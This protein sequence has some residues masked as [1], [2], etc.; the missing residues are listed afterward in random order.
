M[1]KILITGSSGF[2]GK[3]L[4][5]TLILPENNK[6]Y[7]ITTCD[8][9]DCDIPFDTFI[10]HDYWGKYDCIVHMGAVSE[11][12]ATDEYEIYK[13]NIDFTIKLLSKYSNTDCKI[14]YASSASVYGNLNKIET[15]LQENPNF[16]NAISRYAISKLVIDNIVRN[17]YS[18]NPIIGL[19]FF[20]VCSN[21][22]ESHK[23][24][25]SP[26]Y[27]FK[28]ELISNNQ[29]SLFPNSYSII[30]DFIHISDVV[31]I[32][33]FFID[34]EDINKA[35]IVNVGT[36]KS[37]SF[38]SIA[39]ALIMKYGCTKTNGFSS[40]K[41]IDPPSNLTVSYQKFTQADISKLRAM[42]YS[43]DI[44]SILEKL[45]TKYE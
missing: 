19:R 37:I 40:K 5:K 2:I 9:K 12:N 33:K 21:T 6:Y 36:S 20:N 7:H 29:I 38:E 22:L 27:K 41:Y 32:I 4:F 39:D 24:Q 34:K 35:D 17:F 25:P 42:G 26:T 28:Q 23:K 14:I 45:D 10:Q 31:D 30:R 16:E 13:N 8:K 3:Q 11:T 15:P 43:K 44:P 1:K 18:T